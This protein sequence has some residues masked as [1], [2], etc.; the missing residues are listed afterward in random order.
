MHDV[1]DHKLARTE[2][3]EELKNET[4]ACLVEAG[5][6]GAKIRHVFAIW[7][8]LGFKGALD[9]PSMPSLEGAL[10]LDA[11]RLDALGAI[12]AARCFA[13]GGKKGRLLYNP[14]EESRE[15]MDA[16]SYRAHEGS[17]LNHFDE[18]LFHLPAQMLTGA[19][20]RVAE[21]RCE[22]LRQFK[23]RF[24]LEWEGMDL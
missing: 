24:L 18:K 6:S 1:L 11:D 2:E 17:S 16:Q 3:I 15:F 22:F 7:E 4:K 14:A 20:R 23:E 8:N 9:R 21:H 10:V 19:G 13:Y 12:G 5:L